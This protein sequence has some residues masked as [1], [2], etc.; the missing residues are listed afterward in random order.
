MNKKELDWKEA[1]KYLADIRQLYTSIG[2]NGLPALTVIINPL[3]LRFE[4]GERT[5]KLYD[6]IMSLE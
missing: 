3:L 5:Q 6:L 1:E 2:V 4:K